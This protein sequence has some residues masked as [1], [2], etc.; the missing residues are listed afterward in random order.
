M[1]GG[2]ES[3]RY[4]YGMSNTKQHIM[5]FLDI[6]EQAD[7]ATLAR[8]ISAANTKKIRAEYK[9]ANGTATMDDRVTAKTAAMVIRDCERLL[10]ER[11]IVYLK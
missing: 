8:S 2:V 6:L 10:E 4:F 11:G 5:T 9:I 1:F 3:V 7:N